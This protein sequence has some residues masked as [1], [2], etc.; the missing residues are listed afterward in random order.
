M[1]CELLRSQSTTV[2][3]IL[4]HGVITQGPDRDGPKHGS[5]DATFMADRVSDQSPKLA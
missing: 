5:V 3:P 2:T 1:D 4:T